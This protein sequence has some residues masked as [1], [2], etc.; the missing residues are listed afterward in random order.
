MATDDENTKVSEMSLTDPDQ[1]D[2]FTRAIYWRGLLVQR[3]A[4]VEF[5]I[6]HLL[7]AAS[8]RYNLAELSV[9]PFGLKKKLE[10]LRA[11]SEVE[12]PIGDKSEDILSYLEAFDEFADIRQFM[13]HGIM[14][15]TDSG[16]I[17]FK[18]YQHRARQFMQ[19]ELLLSVNQIKGI[20]ESFQPL[21]TDF[22]TLLLAVC[23]QVVAEAGQIPK[24]NPT[25]P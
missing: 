14:A 19:G 22:N 15:P 9:V 10:R 13:V 11:L 2:S 1:L 4:A 16:D 5:S 17:V 20:A 23:R 7:A 24:A 21:S 25:S 12:G 3:Y 8:S 18:V 6:T